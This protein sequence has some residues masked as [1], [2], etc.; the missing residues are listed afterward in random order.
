MKKQTVLMICGLLLL[1]CTN[2]TTDTKDAAEAIEIGSALEQGAT[3][4]TP[5]VA[6]DMSNQDLWKKFVQAANDE[7]LEIMAE[8]EASDIEIHSFGGEVIKGSKNHID[9]CRDW[10]KA[11][12]P[13]WQIRLMI[14]NAGKNKDG[15]LDQWLTTSADYTDTDENGKEVLEQHMY[16]VNFENGKINKVFCYTRNKSVETAE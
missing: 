4:M 1:G 11:S 7:N 9:N 16:D 12:D 3:E 2:T 10:F 5:V 14:A 8:L 13:N 6:G 15:N